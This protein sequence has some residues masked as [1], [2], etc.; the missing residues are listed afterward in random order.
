MRNLERGRNK[1]QLQ[2]SCRQAVLLVLLT[3]GEFCRTQLRAPWR[4]HALSFGLGLPGAGELRLPFSECP[5]VG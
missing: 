1:E 4:H 3:Q 5:D 2:P